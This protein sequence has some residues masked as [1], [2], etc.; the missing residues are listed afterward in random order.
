MNYTLSVYE[1]A[2]PRDLDWPK[3]LESARRAG[4]DAVELSVDERPDFLARLD[5]PAA[6]RRALLGH[7]RRTGVYLNT[8]CLSAHR[9]YP[10]GG[11]DSQ[12]EA[13]RIMQGA[14]NLAADLGIRLIQLAGYDVYY[15]PST[16]STRARFEENLAKCV[17]MA[18]RRAVALG[19]ETMETPFMN[20]AAKAMAY[21][22]KINSPYLG[23]YPDVGNISNAT[24]DVAGD[25]ES[26][27]GRIF[28]AHLKET[29]PGVFRDLQFG[30]GTV[31]FAKC[32]Q[33]LS[34]LGV[35]MYNAEFWYDA[36]GDY[37]Q[38]MRN[39]NDFLRAHLDAQN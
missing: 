25:L 9:K 13:L 11:R 23:V 27:R 18:A 38:A 33:V 7:T 31:N 1:K 36:N 16:P 29:R 19:F 35:R 2:M 6:T 28:A 32:A 5:W 34:G 3:K 22:R 10:L 24:S 39:A 4:F 17:E 26:A 30:Q 37:E 20:T 14:V 12:K 21:V 8:M 15:E